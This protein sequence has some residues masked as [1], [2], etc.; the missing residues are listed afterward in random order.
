MVA[1]GLFA[2][3]VALFIV[4][5]TSAKAQVMPEEEKPPLSAEEK[6]KEA[7]QKLKEAE[8]GLQQAEEAYETAEEKWTAD[9]EGAKLVNDNEQSIANEEGAVA[10]ARN[11][12][13]Q[14]G[15]KSA[16]LDS[17]PLTRWTN[18]AKKAADDYNALVRIF[19]GSTNQLERTRQTALNNLETF[20]WK[21]DPQIMEK[22]RDAREQREEALKE[23]QEASDAQEKEEDKENKKGG[24][25]SSVEPNTT[26]SG[27][28]GGE[29]LASF[30]SAGRVKVATAGTGEVIGHIADFII[31][32]VTDQPIACSIPPMILESGSGKNQ[33]YA[34]PKREDVALKPHEKKKV[35]IDGVCLNRNKSP[36]GKGVGGD[37]LMNDG[38]DKVPS[39]RHLKARDADKLLRLC[40]AK[41]D[42]VDKLQKEGKLDDLPYK[43][44]KKQRDICV[45]WSTW[46]DPR[47]CEITDAPPATKDDLKK[48]VYKQVEEQGPLTEEK[49]KKIDDGIDK[50]FEKIE[51]TS[52][53]AKD[54]EKAEP[55]NETPPPIPPGTVEVTNDTPTP[56]PQAEEKPKK[57]KKKKKWP[58]PIQDWLD[59]HYAADKA[60]R[61]WGKKKMTYLNKLWDYIKK[62]SPHTQELRDK[63]EAASKKANEPGSSQADRDAADTA[64]KEVKKQMD[65]LEKDYQK[66]PEGKGEFDKVHEA[67]KV[68]GNADDAEKEAEKK[69]PPGIDKEGVLEEDALKNG[70]PAQW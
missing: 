6:V 59:K 66:T 23:L 52:E 32:N 18:A 54:L 70:V 49:K 53:K 35:P 20:M 27:A 51:L 30:V 14:A 31:E 64:E 48:V 38:S 28:G 10:K 60:H 11:D 26:A 37:L 50:I 13:K 40:T 61:E 69:L 29:S 2:A 62:N 43:D 17:N 42:A 1:P 68:K 57:E 22:L 65:E 41:Y 21:K 15:Q 7:T 12:A 56:A 5:L 46:T 16:M 4:S 36:V 58:K 9:G 47:I 44:K 19:V 63:A 33:H 67:E 3:L 55:G 45:Q 39:D 34:C 24:K 25:S 8:Q